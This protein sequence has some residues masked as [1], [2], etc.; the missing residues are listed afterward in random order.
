MK[1][2]YIISIII[3]LVLLIATPVLAL[4]DISNADWYSTITITNTGTAATTVTSNITGMTT[5]SLISGGY[6]NATATD[7]AIRNTTGADA[8][9]M[10]GYGTNPWCIYT[11]NMS[12]SSVTNY[13][14]YTK[15]V[16]GG[17]HYYFP[18]TTG[19]EVIDHPSLEIGDDGAA[20]ITTFLGDSTTIISKTGSIDVSYNATSQVVT[21]NI[22]G[23][24]NDTNS[25]NVGTSNSVPVSHPTGFSANDLLIVWIDVYAVDGAG[26][27]TITTPAGFTQ[28]FQTNYN[29][30]IKT[31]GAWYKV[32]TGL[33]ADPITFSLSENCF[34]SY[35][36]ALIPDGIFTG[37]P[38]CGATA[39]GAAS[40]PDS[41][42]LVSGFGAVATIWF[43]N[44]GSIHL[45]TAAPA[46]Y[47][48]LLS[49]VQNSA[50]TT[51]AYLQN[52]AASENPGAFASAATTWAAN[53]VA[54][55]IA[56]PLSLTV[57]NVAIGEYDISLLLDS[58]NMTI[59]VGSSSNTT[60]L[61]GTFISDTGSNWQ[62]GG[63]GTIYVESMS[64]DVG[65]VPVSAWEWEYAA[66]FS[67][68]IGS[69]DGTP[70][71]RTASSDADVT[72]IFG[73]LLPISEAIAPAFA[74]GAGPDFLT[75]NITISG[76]PNSVNASGVLDFPG[77]AIIDD[78][79]GITPKQMIY[80]IIASFILLAI[81]LV[82]SHFLKEAGASSI[83][84][85]SV[86]NIIIYGIL[87]A[88]H[89][90]DWWMLI[91]FFI[92]EQSIWFAA[93]ERRE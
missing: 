48:D 54:V 7:W 64:V 26:I 18:D 40:S 58:V 39:T 12:A 91:F 31:F 30:N 76:T 81:S 24:Y 2:W 38:V 23:V 85:K 19:M 75:D 34:Y 46:G 51:I 90:F 21:A 68:S 57:S 77:K 53:T 50:C 33:E 14:L 59:N 32:V 5:A 69:N 83:F 9:A 45:V 79:S 25:N 61:A 13:V 6:L 49:Q 67:D 66:T 71:F 89:I 44:S 92:F 78:I 37:V 65:G 87:I 55:R 10:A 72:G 52:S 29:T 3:L 62:F 43:A 27:V 22:N 70:S 84:I 74:V 80:I 86:A 17:L 16:T 60:A 93:K 15:N 36:T 88:L 4:S 47:S 28:L 82:V 63:A 73:P 42:N 41:P 35:R 20:E 1:Y 8:P 56:P 11:G